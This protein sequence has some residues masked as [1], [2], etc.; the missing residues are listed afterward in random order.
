MGV[1][2]T[3]RVLLISSA[4]FP[5]FMGMNLLLYMPY[6]M[7]QDFPH[8]CG[9][10]PARYDEIEKLFRVFPTHVGMNPVLSTI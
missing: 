3:L 1:Y 5:M 8:A 10:E 2:L 4:Y 9:D 7:K 6:M